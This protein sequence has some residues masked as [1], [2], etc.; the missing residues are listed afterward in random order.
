MAGLRQAPDLGGGEGACHED[1][2]VDDSVERMLRAAPDRLAEGDVQMLPVDGVDRVR[3][4]GCA[5]LVQHHA[6][7]LPVH[8]R[9]QA[10]LLSEAMERVGGAL[11]LV[12]GHVEGHLA[13]HQPE[14]RQ[15]VAAAAAE[16]VLRAGAWPD[17]EPQRDRVVAAE[18][19]PAQRRVDVR[20]FA[21]VERAPGAEARR[22]ADRARRQDLRAG[23]PLARHGLVE[24]Q[25]ADQAALS[26]EIAADGL[27]HAVEPRLRAVDQPCGGVGQEG[28]GQSQANEDERGFDRPLHAS[29]GRRD[30]PGRSGRKRPPARSGD[31]PGGVRRRSAAR[32]R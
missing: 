17:R 8:G 16:D 2:L 25:E 21:P 6:P 18:R 24:R 15:T 4:H 3:G 1:R 13:V 14:A 12:G 11:P 29:A 22:H 9:R 23:R 20:A 32:R 28:G 31:P 19:G 7:L 27:D 26:R 10:D 30:G 5:I